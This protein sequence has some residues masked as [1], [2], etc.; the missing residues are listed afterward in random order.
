MDK[1]YKPTIDEFHVGFEYEH[2][3][4]N[5]WN[6]DIITILDMEGDSNLNSIYENILKVRVKYLDEDD[7]KSLGWD[8]TLTNLIMS[9]GS[10]VEDVI[11]GGYIIDNVKFY[12]MYDIKDKLC[13]ITFDNGN[14]YD[15]IR[16]AITV[17]NK[18]ELK[19]IMKQLNIIE[20]ENR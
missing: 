13:R 15:H 19:K 7:I 18:S 3:S 8:L 4:Y 5:K 17:K 14:G 20:D 9:D 1:Y 6:K 12:I 2:Y 10:K 11:T 16:V